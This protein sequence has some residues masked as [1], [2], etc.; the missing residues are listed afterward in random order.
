MSSL[1]ELTEEETPLSN[2][3]PSLLS[4]REDVLRVGLGSSE[5]NMIVFI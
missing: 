4:I 3:I 1:G 2:I 5:K